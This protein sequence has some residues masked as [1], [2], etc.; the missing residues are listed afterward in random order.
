MA[1]SYASTVFNAPVD[2]VWQL[3]R[4]YDGMAGWHPAVATSAIE[5]DTPK[6]Q[7]GSVR[8][9]TLKDGAPIVEKLLAFDDDARSLTYAILE[10]PF[11]CTDYVS[12]LRVT[13]VTD[14][15]TTF[16]EWHSTYACEPGRE[17]E[18]ESIFAGAVYKGGFDGLRPRFA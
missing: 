5:G 9:L 18:L 14:A 1:S 11:P 10:G 15:G 13:P 8:R 16:V 6:D 2:A 17:A 3:L 12:T 7:A 4:D